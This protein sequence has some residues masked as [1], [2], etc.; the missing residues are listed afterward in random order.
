MRDHCGACVDPGV[1]PGVEVVLLT[2][3]T[4]SA[5][6]GRKEEEQSW[7]GGRGQL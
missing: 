5:W 7:E 6:A 1:D 2:D 3:G 4:A